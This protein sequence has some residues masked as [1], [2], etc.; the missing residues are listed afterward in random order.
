M[1]RA[2]SDKVHLAALL[3]LDSERDLTSACGG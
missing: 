1:L 3:L 2:G